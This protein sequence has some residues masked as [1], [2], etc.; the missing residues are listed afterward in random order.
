MA[1]SGAC[2]ILNITSYRLVARLVQS[3]CLSALVIGAA[4]AAPAPRA[5]DLATTGGFNRT[6]AT[7][8]PSA[9]QLTNDDERI[10][11]AVCH[12]VDLVRRIATWF[13][14][15]SRAYNG[16]Q[17][18]PA[19]LKA[20]VERKLDL[21]RDD[22][23]RTRV[24]LERVDLKQ[25]SSLR[26][27]PGQWRVDLDGDGRIE[28]WEANF[29]A[30]PRRQGGE[31]KLAMPS[32]DAEHYNRHYN[33]DAQIAV[34][35]ADVLWALSYHQFIE[36]LMAN[37]RAF[38]I[39]VNTFAVTLARPALL[40]NAHLLIGQGLATSER[41]RLSV[42]AETDDDHEWLGHPGQA[43][44]AFP[45]PLEAADF[46][47]WGQVLAQMQSLW[48]G[49]HLLPTTRNAR[50]LLAELAP[51]CEPGEGLDLAKLYLQ[52]PPAGTQAKLGQLRAMGQGACRKVDAGHPVSDLPA[53][54]ERSRSGQASG[55][56]MLRYLYWVN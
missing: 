7:L 22:L 19:Q 46:A 29:F 47:T 55:T 54:L 43:S 35:Q 18:S 50:G 5:L 21:V 8:P 11:W 27:A 48:Q 17:A 10:A 23:R 16:G 36:G 9:A 31:P 38:D 2:T 20:E 39:D 1:S 33:Q 4:F 32:N 14:Q 45:I 34:D 28:T 25:R 41:L 51:V 53:W 37:V 3:T 13:S 12:D 15:G 44:S 40:R 6:C 56:Q 49:R 24:Q 42:L 30:I 52:P 26:L